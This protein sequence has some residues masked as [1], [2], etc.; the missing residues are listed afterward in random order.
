M[1]ERDD[2]LADILRDPVRG[3][4]LLRPL[5]AYNVFAAK[6]GCQI[7]RLSPYWERNF[8]LGDGTTVRF[9]GVTTTLLSG[10]R[11]NYDTHR[12][13]YGGAQRAILREPSVRYALVGHHPPSWTVEGDQ[14]DHVFST[15][16][17]LQVFGHKHEQ[18]LTRS[19]NSV[20]L[21]SGAVHPS[22][23][24]QNWLPRYAAIAI[25]ATDDRHLAI[26]I[27]PRRWSGEDFTF[28]GDYNYLDQDYRD[29]TV[30]VE[31]RQI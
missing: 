18:W 12:M 1:Q 13:C 30:D 11:D 17:F 6:Y 10:P 16:S 8:P 22:R 2:R 20:R 28:V 24:E 31:P 19:G 9:R 29:F 7:S 26:R 25:S 23:H 27:Y 3:E 15:L 21:I 4:V 5:S 14:A